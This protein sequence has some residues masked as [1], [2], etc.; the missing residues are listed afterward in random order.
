VEHKI[1]GRNRTSRPHGCQGAYTCLNDH[2]FEMC[3]WIRRNFI[4]ATGSPHRLSLPLI[5]S[6]TEGSY[7][8]PV[9]QL[10]KLLAD[11]ALIPSEWMHHLGVL[12]VAQIGAGAEFKKQVFYTRDR[13]FSR[14]PCLLSVGIIGC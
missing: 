4:I 6:R 1:N 2:G 12:P 3:P 5:E 11:Q 14:R 8:I 7:R 10:V 9:A 13:V